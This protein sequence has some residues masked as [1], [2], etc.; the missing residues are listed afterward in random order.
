MI[1][2]SS[3]VR[4]RWTMNSAVRCSRIYRLV[5]DV[6][7]K[8]EVMLNFKLRTALTDGRVLWA[9]FTKLEGILFLLYIVNILLFLIASSYIITIFFCCYDFLPTAFTIYSFHCITT[10]RVFTKASVSIFQSWWTKPLVTSMGRGFLAKW[11]PAWK[12]TA[13][14]A[15]LSYKRILTLFLRLILLEL[16]YLSNK[17]I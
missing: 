6:F 3:R 2:P 4:L 13:P 1:I 16:K 12:Y 5:I 7:C 9:V 15:A 8:T 11:A 17:W 10:S 14:S